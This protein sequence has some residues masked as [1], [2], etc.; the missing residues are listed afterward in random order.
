MRKNGSRTL[1][2]PMAGRR[3]AALLLPFAILIFA[4][5]HGD[6]AEAEFHIPQNER[7][8]LI[9][10]TFAD[11]L[12]HFGWLETRLQA[13][14]PEKRLTVRNLGWSG[15][16]VGLMPR[17]LNFGPLETHLAN[18]EADTILMCFGANESFA[19]E[20]GLEPFRTDLRALID[21]LRAEPFNGETPPRLVLVSPIAHEPLGDPWPDAG[22]RNV[23]LERYTNVM[24][25]E[26]EGAGIRFIDLFH[27]TRTRMPAD[28]EVPLTINGIHLTDEGYRLVSGI[29]CLGLGIRHPLPVD[30]G[31]L[32]ALR[33]LILEK[34]RQFM[35]RWRP[36]NAEYVFGRRKEPFGV[37]TFPPEMEQLERQIKALDEE[38]H[39]ATACLAHEP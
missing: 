12:Q 25:E 19:G 36:V 28:R 15:D 16:E 6:A 10:N 32:Q 37:L 11:R 8:V 29:L 4:V 30:Q 5:R 1:D 9:G 31:K 7:I 21:R 20:G 14:L 18:W 38:I 2:A 13:A 23:E 27:P 33:E 35:L 34:N 17:P 24:R 3:F 39:A 26:A 22:P